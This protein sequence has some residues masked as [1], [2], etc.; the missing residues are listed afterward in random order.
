M[1]LSVKDVARLFDISEKSV[2]RW[3][4]SDN[5]PHYRINGQYRFSHA[6]LLEWSASHKV[7]IDPHFETDEEK[8][9]GCDF[10][11][12]QALENGGIFYRVEGKIRDEVVR[13]VANY[14]KLP[15]G[16]DREL[17]YQFLLAREKLGTT[18]IGEGI[19]IPHVRNPVVV[20]AETPSVALCFLE[21]PVDF[22]AMDG[23]P[24]RIVFSMVSPSI[25]CHL[26]LLSMLM[27]VLRDEGF[28]QLLDSGASRDRILDAVHAIEQKTGGGEKPA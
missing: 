27:F 13:S 20:R 9:P 5:L 12:S 3:I 19:A 16:T 14:I 21:E 10:T 24:V 6:E 25:K 23:Q 22:G 8:D 17:F 11:L 26:R 18:A 2:Y 1:K 4:A 7:R 15:E 28:R